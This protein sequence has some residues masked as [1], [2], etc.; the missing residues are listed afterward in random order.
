MRDEQWDVFWT[1]LYWPAA[2]TLAAL[3]LVSGIWADARSAHG[4]GWLPALD[5]HYRELVAYTRPLLLRI[6]G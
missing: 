4:G 2:I 6:P 5:E 1:Q 3:P